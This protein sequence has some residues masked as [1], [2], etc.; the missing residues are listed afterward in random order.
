MR[1]RTATLALAAV[2]VAGCTGDDER[3]EA[4]WSGPPAPPAGEDDIPVAEFNA[5]AER[6]DAELLQS[7]LLAASRFL[8]SADREVRDTVLAVTTRGEGATTARVTAT[9]TGVLDDSVHAVRYVLE[10]RR[11][12]DGRWKL[13]SAR[14]T[15]RC[16]RGRGHQTFS[17]ELCL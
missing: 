7:P 9:L 15:H 13:E 17:A 5:Y 3:Q 10:L 16:A 1:A 14:R 11:S 6:A 8:G 4:S 2:L 12:D